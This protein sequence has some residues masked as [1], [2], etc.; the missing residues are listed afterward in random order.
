MATIV[1][2]ST[3]KPPENR[4]PLSLVSPPA[5]SACCGDSR[6]PIGEPQ[7]EGRWIYRYLRCRVCGF[8][9]KVGLRQLPDEQANAVLRA[10]L[11]RQSLARW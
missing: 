10:L 1:E 8:A 6:E 5:A 11:T 9:V 7:T 3:T 4:F 2:Y